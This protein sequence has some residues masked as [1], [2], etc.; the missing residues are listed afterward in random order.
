MNYWLF[1]EVERS[2]APGEIRTP[3]HSLRRDLT[4]LARHYFFDPKDIENWI[5]AAIHRTADKK[6]NVK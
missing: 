2:G 3:D 5:T 1:L 4:F 6:R